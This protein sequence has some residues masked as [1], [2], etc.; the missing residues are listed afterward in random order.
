MRIHDATYDRSSTTAGRIHG[1]AKP[2]A[3]L[4]AGIAA[5]ASQAGRA[6]SVSSAVIAAASY[7]GKLV[8]IGTLTMLFG[9]QLC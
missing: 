4:L 9:V 6:R 8:R 2:T 3:P 7:Y 5:Q 1:E